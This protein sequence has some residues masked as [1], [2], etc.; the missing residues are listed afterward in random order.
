MP[1]WVGV[2]IATAALVTAIGVLWKK[3]LAPLV[4]VSAEARKTVPVMR[5]MT[6]TFAGDPGIFLVIREIALQFKSDSG[7]TLRDVVNRLEAASIQN[8]HAN[9]LL[10]IAADAARLAQEGSRVLA[11]SDR[12]RVDRLIALLAGVD[13]RVKE[14]TASVSRVA[15]G[16]ARSEAGAAVVAE[17][18]AAA[19]E[20]ADA[21]TSTDNPGSA[22][23]AAWQRPTEGLPP[24]KGTP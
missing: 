5:A 19:H 18:L 8:T 24:P 22:S 6:D 14:N 21:H 13:I 2:V 16:V 1:D 23:D 7:S 4:A 15:A 11:A 3:V 20:R 10:G 12:E 9:E 17:D